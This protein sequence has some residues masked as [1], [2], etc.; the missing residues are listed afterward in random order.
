M[1]NGVVFS[2]EYLRVVKEPDGYYIESYKKGMS[3]E[4]FNKLISSHSEIRV[5][6]F[7]AVKNAILY[8]PVSLTK[9]GEAK[10]RINIEIS[11]DEL[12][13]Y[14]TLNVTEDEF[15]GAKMVALI[16]EI[17]AKLKEKGLVYRIKQDV[18]LDGLCN[19]KQILIAEGIPPQNGKDSVIN[20]YELKE[21]KPEIKVD[22]NVD[23]YELN[24]INMV[25]AGDWL[26]ERIDPTPGVP[27]K[28]VKGAVIPAMPG[29]KYPL[30]YDRSTVNEVYKDGVT[31]LQAARN[32]AVH[33]Q[34]D[35]IGVYNHLEIGQNIDF[36]TGNIDFDGFVTVKGS[37]EDSFSVMAD[38]DIEILGEYG[39]GS[40]KEVKSRAGSVYIKGGIAGKNKAVIISNRDI[41]TKF[42]SDATII[43]EGSV[44]IGF[45]CINSDIVA[46][47]V[48][49]DSPKGQIIGGNIKAEIRVVS[50]ILGSPGEKRTNI[51]VKGFNR[52]ALKERLEKT[53]MVIEEL[54]ESLT[55][56]KQEM[57][58][59]SNTVELDRIKL[60]ELE[61]IKDKFFRVK[62]DLKLMED[63]KKVLANYL[64]T[65]GEGEVTIL[66][67]AF[68]G[69]VIGIK[70]MVKEITQEAFGTSFYYSESEIRTL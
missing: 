28:T 43:C 38:K 66:K 5:T 59:Y 25:Y 67:K 62:E 40:V 19:G 54:K 49:L 41:Y 60:A 6:S 36:K 3:V 26:G 15:S 20:M 11:G 39:I 46:K 8:A 58:I 47:E 64:R 51:T 7:M 52:V 2:S 56:V 34:G 31:V 65:H 48:I 33:Y 23:H 55:K 42:V 44:H 10:E 35:I 4:Q 22:G 70:D 63:E 18:L 27:G 68:P 1:D 17:I 9:F 21:P 53:I 12:S 14:I 45:Y 16:K 13:V 57:S 37:I 30:M 32:G 50:S 24:L 29:K 61:A 69:T